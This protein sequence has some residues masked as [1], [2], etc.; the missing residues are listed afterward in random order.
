MKCRKE[1]NYTNNNAYHHTNP[2]ISPYV[3]LLLRNIRISQAKITP[4]TRSSLAAAATDGRI[5]KSS[6]HPIDVLTPAA[7]AKAS[8]LR[9][10][11]EREIYEGMGKK[12]REK[13]RGI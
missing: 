6:F 4:R 12:P 7:K 8:L 2:V 3:L 1:W 11:R 5:G 13:G 10:G 9:G